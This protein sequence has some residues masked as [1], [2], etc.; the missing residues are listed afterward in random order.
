VNGSPRDAEIERLVAA[1]R[2][3]LVAAGM[4]AE[5]PVTSP[6]RSFLARVGVEGW[7]RLA[8]AEQCATSLKDRR[9]VGW[10]MVTGR[11]KPSPDYLVLG[12]PYLGEVAARHRRDFHAAFA[13]TA[14]ELGF[15]ARSI[16][17]QWSATVKVGVLVGVSPD[18]L[19]KAQ[20]DAGR[21]L[22]IAAIRRHRPDSNGVR[23]LTTALFGAEATLFHA[24]VIDTPPRK[25]HPDKSA[26][27]A[28]EWAMVAPRLRGTLQGYI[29][30]MRLSLRASTMVRVEAVLR[31][32]AGWLAAGAPE[33]RAVADLRRAHI[34]RYKRHLADRPSARGG[35][36]SK[37]TLAEHLGCLRACLERL[38][39]WAGE[40]VPAGV[41]VFAGDLPRRDEPLPRFLDD[42][43]AAKLLRAARQDPDPFT[44]LA[45]EFLARTGLRKGE[46]LDLTV[47]AVVQIGSAYWLHVPVGKL[48]TDRY[49]PL[50][51]QLKELLD[52]WLEQRPAGL[53]E[54]YLFIERGRRISK[55]RVDKALAD[56]ARAAGIGHV[57]P[58]QLRHTLAT[59]AINR[60]MSLE[61]IA[62]LLG[63]RSMRMTMVYARIADRTVA[64]EYFAVS[65]KVEALY[66][67][68]REL[69]AEAEGAEMRKLRSELHRRM[70]G[71]GYCARPVGLDCHFESICE[72]C[73]FFQTTLEFRPTLKRQRDDAAEKGQV[74]RQKVFDGLLQRLDEAS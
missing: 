14:G 58:H 13:A 8:L 7:S 39:E 25:R 52:E 17:L 1:Y 22:L 62:A 41:L 43:A 51:P 50:H 56:V 53:R 67:A 57:T 38:S 26:A 21:D 31:E 4:F 2:A 32:F 66:D 5:H 37:T 24:G 35:R 60:G 29:E 45:V 3:D 55:Q 28:R 72:S 10:L 18:R 11:V 73:T 15:D 9:V 19:T 42:G 27:R 20:L 12:R 36:L 70:L 71:N 33:V 54:P 63:H 61:A 30:Q 65:E 47:D 59:Q 16:R 68:P 49:I 23:A 64:D 48:R 74:G 6:A 34:E 69:P 44:R 40:D 46:F